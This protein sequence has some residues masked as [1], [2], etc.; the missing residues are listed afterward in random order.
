APNDVMRWCDE[1]RSNSGTS[2]RYAAVNAPD[3]TTRTSSAHAGAATSSAPSARATV[4]RTDRIT[5]M[6][7]VRGWKIDNMP[8]VAGFSRVVRVS[9]GNFLEM[10]DFMV[11]GYYAAA[12]GNAF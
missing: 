11:F 7:I 4:R 10:Y 8:R 2:C 3:V 6:A 5:G 12:I 1:V 9:C